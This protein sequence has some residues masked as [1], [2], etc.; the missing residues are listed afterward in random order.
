M[1]FITESDRLAHEAQ[2]AIEQAK[3]AAEV[4]A[5]AGDVDALEEHEANERAARRRLVHA[6][7]QTPVAECRHCGR[8]FVPED[9]VE[10]VICAIVTH[11]PGRIPTPEHFEKGK[12][13]HL[14]YCS[15]CAE[16]S[17]LL[18]YLRKR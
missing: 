15:D 18:A 3:K 1:R 16:S 14:V 2:R 6:R 13:L 10:L 7:A 4:A 12:E 17:R 11:E 9:F 8:E 5:H